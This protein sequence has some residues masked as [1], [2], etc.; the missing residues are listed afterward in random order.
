METIKYEEIEG[1]VVQ[2]LENCGPGAIIEIYENIFDKK[3]DEDFEVDWDT[4]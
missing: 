3:I 1:D 4:C 2:F